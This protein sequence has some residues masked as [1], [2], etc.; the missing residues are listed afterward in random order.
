MVWR[1]Q[2]VRATVNSLLQTIGL[3]E[4]PKI[5]TFDNHICFLSSE[6]NMGKRQRVW[7]VLMVVA[8]SCLCSYFCAF[9]VQVKF[10][11]AFSRKYF[12]CSCLRTRWLCPGLRR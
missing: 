9:Y 10:C 12:H 5:R 8:Y 1:V 6:L 7:V 4:E 2:L 11:T 3:S